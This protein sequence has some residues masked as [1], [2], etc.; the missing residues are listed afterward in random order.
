MSNS[1]LEMKRGI[2]MCL[3]GLNDPANM[4]PV[5]GGLSESFR[6]GKTTEVSGLVPPL[7]W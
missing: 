3:S 7:A 1:R 2:R 4:Q 6:F 5:S